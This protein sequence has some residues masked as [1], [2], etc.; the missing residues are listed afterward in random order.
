MKKRNYN[1]RQ[2]LF[3][4][5]QCWLNLAHVAA[6]VLIALLLTRF[7][8]YN[9]SSLSIF[10]PMDKE[11]DFQMSD[12]YNLVADNKVVRDFSQ[13]VI[14]VG[15]DGCSRREVIDA[16]NIISAC[17]PKAIGLDMYFTFPEEDNT[18]FLKTITETPNLVC[19]EMVIQ[20]GQ[21]D[22]FT[23]QP[24]S[25]YQSD[26]HPITGYVNL[27]AD[28]AQHVV[29][30]FRPYVTSSA[31]DTTYS[32]P[33][34]L[35]SIANKEKARQLMNSQQEEVIIDYISLDID[36]I[37]AKSLDVH[38]KK[39]LKGKVVLIGDVNALSDSHLTPVSQ[40]KPGV[41]IHALEL[42]TILSGNYIKISSVWMNWL[43]AVL[44]CIT[45]VSLLLFSKRRMID[46]GSLVLRVGQ[47]LVM[48]LMIYVG[49]IVYKYHHVY[50]DFA[51][52]VLMLG[53]GSLAFDLWFGA[54]ALVRWI[55]EKF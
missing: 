33:Y 6:I 37:H 55:K 52:G 28:D 29:R 23:R 43:M 46:Y 25:F 41:M 50:V 30:T 21:S 1:F 32:M 9:I 26:I 12:F 3:L 17:G 44:I 31:N 53:L 47:F 34:M 11:V 38:T 19:A 8:I 35:A 49:C 40:V 22:H 20:E 36:T 7:T 16:I 54:C 13:D 48:F 45:Y 10:A 14:V 24:L 15:V 51:P 2:R 27:N 5:K 39:W 18:Y 4:H 42:Q